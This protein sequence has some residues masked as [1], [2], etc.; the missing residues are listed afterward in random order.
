MHLHF[1]GH[2][3]TVDEVLPASHANLG[4]PVW[5][6]TGTMYEDLPV[7]IDDD[8]WWGPGSRGEQEKIP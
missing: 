3:Q 8:V 2:S 4:L 6:G 7:R 1:L 5:G